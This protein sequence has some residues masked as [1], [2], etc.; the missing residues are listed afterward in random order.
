MLPEISVVISSYN[1]KNSLQRAVESILAQ[2]GSPAYELIVVDNRSTDGT[3][4]LIER[5]VART[6]NVRYIY[7]DRQGVS[8]GRN[9]GIAAA[10]ASLLAFTDDDVL[11]SQNWL[12]TMKASFDERPEFGCVGGK[13]EAIWPGKTPD[14]LTKRH[15]APLALLDYG[16]EQAIDR[17]NRKCLITANMGIR[18][19]VFEQVGTFRLDVQRTPWVAS[20]IEDRELQERYW[21]AGGRCWFDPRI[22]VYAEIQPFR[23]KKGYHRRWHVSHGEAQAT[24]RDQEFERSGFRLFDVPGHVFRGITGEGLQM[25]C[26]LSLFQVDKAFEHELN[27]RFYAGYIR[28]R[29]EQTWRGKHGDSSKGRA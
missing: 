26:R 10:Q 9:A 15:W 14:W 2:K 29:V 19:S 6:A 24:L 28:K 22:A 11:V 1:R 21:R 5:Y 20:A 17:S 25:A 13:V 4:E 12:S 18:R 16:P 7:E 8:Y 23:L 27:A 3:K